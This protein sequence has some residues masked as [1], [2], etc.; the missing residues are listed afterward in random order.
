MVS[1]MQKEEFLRTVNTLLKAEFAVPLESASVFQLHYAIS[2]AVLTEIEDSWNK[3]LHYDGKQVCYLSAEFLIGR[4]IY[5]NLFNLGLTGLVQELLNPL[6]QD[7]SCFEEITEPALGSSGLGRLAA[8]FLDSGATLHYHLNGYGIRYH[9][10]LFR[11]YFEDGFQKEEGDNWLEQADPWSICRRQ[12]AV[13]VH[14]AGETVRAVPYDMP[15]IGYKSDCINTLRLWQS[16]AVCDFD[17]S[18]FQSQ[19]YDDSIQKRNEADYLCMTLYPNDTTTEG[20]RLRLK[21]QY[22]LCSATMQDLLRQFKQ[23]HGSRFINFPQRYTVQLNDTHPVLAIPEFIRILESQENVSFES[24]FAIARDSFAYTN[25]T[26]ITNT[27]E[28][29]DYSLIEDT[30]PEIARVIQEIHQFMLRELS[31]IKSIQILYGGNVYMTNLAVYCSFAVNGI[32]KLHSQLLQKEKMKDWYTL[33]P[34]RFQNKTNG[35]TPRRWIGLANPEL[36]KL[37]TTLLGSNA[38]L[39]NLERLKD[40][41]KYADDE[42]IL[43]EFIQIKDAK[44]VQLSGILLDREHCLL[45]P[46]S[47]FDVQI[48]QLLECKRQLL[49]A[50]CILAI[51][52]RLKAGKIPQ[53]HPMTCI[54]GAKAFPNNICAKAIIKYINEIATLINNDPDMQGCLKV[55]FVQNYNV[56]YAE[57]IIPA[58]DVSEQISTAGTEASGTGN[59]KLMLNGAVTLGTY[60]SANLEI[61]QQAGIENNYLFGCRFEELEKMGDHY[62]AKKWYNGNPELKFVVDTLIDGTFDDGGTGIFKELYDSLIKGTNQHRADQYFLFADFES[63]LNSRLAVNFDYGHPMLFARKCW[64]N[65]CNSGFFSSDRTIKEYAKQIWNL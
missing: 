51:Y 25:H 17:Y 11:Q 41:E 32:A 21:Q 42:E 61:V 44:K 52:Y 15:V 58:T 37:I 49:N 28:I 63:Y 29:W 27:Q 26:L 62:Q 33:Y 60:D 8:C 30:L 19:N 48:K 35:I 50:F 43:T 65:L 20:K 10:G 57:K 59:M 55:V 36:S 31:P 14:F 18:L 45:D 1:L 47:L 39:K 2:K 53:F 3:Q 4:S 16:E 46:T 22:F 54:F 34:N 9:K 12:E 23:K 64:L 6:G 13:L 56:S 7:F 40:L 38:W 24:A 5:Q